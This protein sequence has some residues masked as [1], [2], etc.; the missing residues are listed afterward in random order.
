MEIPNVGRL[1]RFGGGRRADLLS[2]IIFAPMHSTLL[3]WGSHK[4]LQGNRRQKRSRKGLDCAS[5]PTDLSGRYGSGFTDIPANDEFLDCESWDLQRLQLDVHNFIGN[6]NR[7]MRDPWMGKQQTFFIVML[8][9]LHLFYRLR[10]V[11]VK[12]VLKSC[13]KNAYEV[14]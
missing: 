2:G 3:A 12:L 11:Y 4:F 5:L 10:I 9:I 7:I 8:L 13:L 6:L 14:R 1:P